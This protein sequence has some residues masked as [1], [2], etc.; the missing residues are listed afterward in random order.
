MSTMLIANNATR[1]SG[2]F[3]G[4]QLCALK[5]AYLF[6]ESEP[7]VDHVIMSVSPG[8]E[9]HFLWNKFIEKFRVDL[10][11]DDW[12]PGDWEARHSAWD[13]WRTERKIEGRSFDKYR[14]LYLRIHGDKRQYELCGEER[15]LGR[16]NIYSYWYC[17]QEH[18]PDELPPSADWFDDSLV[19]HPPRKPVRDV[20]VAPHAKTQGNV[21]FTFEFWDDVVHRLVEAG[22]SVTV[23]YDRDFCEDLNGNPLYRKH[24]GSHEEWM[25]QLCAHKI[26]A[27]G[28][29]GAG[30][31]AAA[32]GV[33]MITME[34]HNSVMA[35]HRYRQCG[36]R[37]IIQV[38]DGHVL[39]SMGNDM[40]KA[41]DYV[42]RRLIE[43]VGGNTRSLDVSTICREA[44]PHSVNPYN[45]LKLLADQLLLVADMPGAIADLGAYRG[46]ASLV[47]RR[48]VP[49]KELFVYDTWEGNPYD[50]ELCHHK[51]GEWSAS[52]EGCKALVGNGELTHYVK[53]VFPQS[54]E[55]LPDKRF[56]FVYVDADTYQAT[57]DAIKYFWPRMV[58]GGRI[59]FD[60]VPWEPCAGVEKAINEVLNPDKQQRFP[61][62]TAVVMV[63]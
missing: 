36:L 48:L 49:D 42:A 44:A 35:D 46:G 13:K 15:G 60:D 1:E 47:M 55:E 51:K 31:L 17:G 6:V 29:T 41:A 7:T 20:Y 59:L 12:N 26:V 58:P 57:S 2:S 53:G 56:C 52:A 3:M 9:M 28:N 62:A 39:D 33:P 54:A 37:N 45:K 38:V 5:A 25:D 43:E 18:K 10:V 40:V 22:G 32:C 4:D 27:C 14:E 34:P 63:K 23:G 21:T 24:W 8:N 61:E 11:Y 16:R 19:H 50:D 30:W